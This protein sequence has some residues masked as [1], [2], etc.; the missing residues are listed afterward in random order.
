MFRCLIAVQ[1]SGFQNMYKLGKGNIYLISN[2]AL[3]R[4]VSGAI[5]SLFQVGLSRELWNIIS[6]PYLY[7]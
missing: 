5:R 6:D 7:A 3:S 1:S 4:D 2:A